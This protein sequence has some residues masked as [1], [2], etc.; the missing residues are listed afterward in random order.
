MGTWSLNLPA[1]RPANRGLDAFWTGMDVEWP[2]T[3]APP[4]NQYEPREPVA[5]SKPS[6]TIQQLEERQ[7]F[8]PKQRQINGAFDV[9]AGLYRVS[10]AKAVNRFLIHRRFVRE[11]L[12]EAYPRIKRVFG[13]RV[14]AELRLVEDMEDNLERLRVNIISNDAQARLALEQFDEEWWLDRVQDS[15]G[16]LDF[17]LKRDALRLE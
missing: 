1:M 12:F 9:L 16:L 10:D 3:E 7:S 6:Q 14:H 15:E 5:P 11:L 2:S 4:E 17:T 8:H 13:E